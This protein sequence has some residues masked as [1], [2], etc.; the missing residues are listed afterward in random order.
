M[1]RFQYITLIP[2][3]LILLIG[4]STYAQNEAFTTR[5][6]KRNYRKWF[7]SV[8][9][10]VQISGYKKVDFVSSNVSPLI[11][12]AAGKWF[13]PELAIR[14]G[15]K[16]PYFHTI[17]NDEK[18]FY[19]YFYSEALFNISQLIAG[20]RPV[21]GRYAFLAYA[22]SGY[23]YNET[24]GRPNVC[25]NLGISNNIRLLKGLS[26]SFDISAIIGWDIYQGDEDIL[27]GASVSIS[28]AF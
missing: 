20:R 8:A 5:S 16:G 2:L 19:R 25:A 13:A 7:V 6:I 26:A 22:G 24:Y 23:F 17:S 3:W 21:E 11:N 15:Y 14:V 27:P 10:G 9:G 28:Y 18:N 4:N 12:I 1:R